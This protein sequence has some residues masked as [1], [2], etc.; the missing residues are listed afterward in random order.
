MAKKDALKIETSPSEIEALIS[1]FERNELTP[2]DRTLTVRLLRLVLMLVSL[3]ERKNFTIARLRRMLFGPSSDSR[4]SKPEPG[5]GGRGQDARA[6][7]SKT[8]SSRAASDERPPGHGRRPSSAMRSGSAASA[9]T[10][11]S[12]ARP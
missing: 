3:L 10:P 1:R 6:S 11:T 5:G 8:D 7:A 4:T 9:L 2:E 12:R